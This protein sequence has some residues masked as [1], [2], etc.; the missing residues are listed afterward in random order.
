MTERTER[1]AEAIATK[2]R[3]RIAEATAMPSMMQGVALAA[4]EV[5]LR[6]EIAALLSEK[7]EPE[8]SVLEAAALGLD[9][10]PFLYSVIKSGEDVT[11][12]V[13][14][15]VLKARDAR[16]KVQRAIDGTP[17]AK[18]EAGDE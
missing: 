17:P 13:T 6:D 9:Q 18:R 15:A 3:K 12:H 5:D 11:E 2:V 10:V 8:R 7:R 1:L 4:I 14:D 16:I